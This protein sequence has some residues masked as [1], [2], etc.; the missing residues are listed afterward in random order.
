V[1][2]E[3]H[4]L[5]ANLPVYDV[6]TLKEHLQLPLFPLHAA[7]AAVGS[8][9][10]VAL[11]LAAIGIYGVMAY[12]VSQR[13]QEIGIRMALGART[14][15]V[16]G[17]VLRHGIGITVAGMVLGLL[18]AFGLA[19]VVTNLLY[20]VSATDPSTFILISILLAIVALMACVIPARRATR[21]DPVIAIKNL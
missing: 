21:V 10:V 18:C 9:G 3:V 20:G 2:N 12:S 15:D 16:W 4:L 19:R 17:M 11:I 13:T 8:F 6:K 1:R 5:D 7:A 14:I